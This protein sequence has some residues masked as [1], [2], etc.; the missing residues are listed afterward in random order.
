MASLRVRTIV[1]ALGQFVHTGMN[2]VLALALARLLAKESYGTFRQVLFIYAMLVGILGSN[3]AESLLYFLPR[4]GPGQ[5]PQWLGQ[6]TQ[7][8]LGVGLV[9]SM[10]LYFMS[11][12]WAAQFDNPELSPL[13]KVFAFFPLTDRI[14][15]MVPPALIAEDCAGWAA[16][17]TVLLGV[18]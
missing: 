11:D 5:K 8:S 16:S 14:V 13:L 18:A 17:F 3:I 7:L 2:V 15:R 4:A 10:I 1:L 9:L 6:T 12:L